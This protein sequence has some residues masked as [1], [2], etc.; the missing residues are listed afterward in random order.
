[1]GFCNAFDEHLA[2][3]A[4]AAIFLR[5]HEGLWRFDAS[6]TRDAWERNPGPHE[7]GLRWVHVR[8]H[9]TGFVVCVLVTSPTLLPAHPRGDVRTFTSEAEAF[10]ALDAIGRPP[11]TRDAL[12]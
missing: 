7:H 2:S 10:E 5:D 1:M 9:Q 6:W 11:V 8:D 12:C 4:T 3:H